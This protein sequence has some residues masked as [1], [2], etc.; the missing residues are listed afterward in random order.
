MTYGVG[1]VPEVMLCGATSD[2]AP[3]GATPPVRA[4]ESVPLPLP[5]PIY[6]GFGVR[7]IVPDTVAVLVADMYWAT[8]Y[9][10]P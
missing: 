4:K 2:I 9:P 3:E 1:V 8:P 5:L 10:Q 7:A 6:S